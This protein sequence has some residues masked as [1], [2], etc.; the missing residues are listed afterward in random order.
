M[1]KQIIITGWQSQI[2]TALYE[3]DQLTELWTE[4]EESPVRVGDIYI[5]KVKHVVPN[6][7][8]AFIAVSYTHLTLPTICS[9]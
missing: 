6:I 3:N 2:L 8:A 9:V 1:K 4:P 7:Q 5:G